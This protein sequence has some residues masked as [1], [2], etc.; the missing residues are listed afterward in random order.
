MNIQNLL[1]RLEKVKK[2]GA[3][4]GV[5]NYTARCPAHAD[6]GPSLSIGDAPDGRILIK[7]FAG[8]EVEAVV[9][10]LGISLEDLFPPKVS[11]DLRAP[12]VRKPWSQR[13]VAR[14]FELECT[15]AFL[16]LAKIGGGAAI[17]K[18]DRQ[19]AAFLAPHLASMLME[20]SE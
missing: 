5:Q 8:C 4:N 18:L 6:K 11:D 20:I 3:R 17:S 13:D 15:E 14:A 19:R 1:G 12:I 10:A 9:S 16:L 2:S 7:C